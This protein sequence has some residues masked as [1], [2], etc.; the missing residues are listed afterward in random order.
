MRNPNKV[1]WAYKKIFCSIYKLDYASR[2]VGTSSEKRLENSREVRRDRLTN[3]E[4]EEVIWI[5]WKGFWDEPLEKIKSENKE[6]DH[7]KRLRHGREG[8][9]TY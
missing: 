1:F 5:T 8:R 9:S 4:E 3:G 7:R 6:F 2:K